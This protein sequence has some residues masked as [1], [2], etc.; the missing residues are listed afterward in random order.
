MSDQ[1][2]ADIGEETEVQAQPSELDMLKERA[3]LMSI[4][5][6]NRIGVDALRAKIDA[7]L[8]D[9]PIPA[10]ETDEPETNGL[11]ALSGESEAPEGETLD[12]LRQRLNREC[13]RLIRVR[14]TNLD[15]KKKDLPGE[16]ITVGND[17]IGTVKKFVPFGEATDNGYHLPWI[18]YEELRSRVFLN[19]RTSK[20][21]GQIQVDSGWAR[22]FSLEVL[23]PLTE[24]E[25]A[26]L[27]AAQAAGN[28]IG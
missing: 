6:S 24:T 8:E 20:K 5:F 27:A 21:A 23:P 18:I 17:I 25:L 12:Q 7:K 26:R 14:I 9:R 2:N 4:P 1:N 19:I 15:P 22:E 13:M 11:A 3:R 28:N 10:D 16:I